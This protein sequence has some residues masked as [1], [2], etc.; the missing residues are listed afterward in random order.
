MATEHKSYPLNNSLW[1]LNVY[2]V[3]SAARWGSEMEKTGSL[4]WMLNADFLKQK[5]VTNSE[6]S[7]WFLLTSNS[8]FS[9]T[10]SSKPEPCLQM[11]SYMETQ[12]I[13]QSWDHSPWPT[14]FSS[15]SS[16]PAPSLPP[17][18]SAGSP[19]GVWGFWDM[20]RPLEKVLFPPLVWGV[21]DP[22]HGLWDPLHFAPPI[23]QPHELINPL[24][25]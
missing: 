5:N 6:N 20:L 18:A 24:T 2:H 14:G 19:M 9:N 13:K 8:D 21:S 4:L 10:F 25:M 22:S 23:S 15:P 11:K 12:N 17:R 1:T 16:P 7:G 3:Q